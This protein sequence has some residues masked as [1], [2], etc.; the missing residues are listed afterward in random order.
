MAESSL[1]DKAMTSGLSWMGEK[2]CSRTEAGFMA[3]NS[4]TESH[5]VGGESS[6]ATDRSTRVNGRTESEAATENFR[7]VV[8]C[9]KVFSTMVVV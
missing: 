2:V 1:R 8:C 3:E 6:F 7:T 4:E 5:T 9:K